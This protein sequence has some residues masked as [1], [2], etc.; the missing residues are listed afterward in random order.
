MKYKINIKPLTVNK[1][2]KGKRFKTKEYKE[3]E[4]FA[5]FILPNNFKLPN[6]YLDAYYEFVVS[7]KLSDWDKPIKPFQD[8]LKKKYK[9]DDNLI[10]S[11]YVK[12]KI[13]KKGNEYIKFDLQNLDEKTNI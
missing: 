11:A 5:M 12:K 10:M 6:G 13:V 4:K 9:F 1:A 7:S 8:I 2:W 3:F